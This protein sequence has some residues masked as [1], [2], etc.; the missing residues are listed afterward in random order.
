MQRATRRSALADRWQI[1]V[2][3]N[4]V[5][6]GMVRYLTNGR[7][8]STFGTGGVAAAVAD[9]G[10]TNAV[11][12]QS[13]G[14]F[15]VAGLTGGP[16]S[17]LFTAARYNPN[18]TRDTAFGKNGLTTASLNG[19]MGVGE[20]VLVQPDDKILIGATALEGHRAIPNTALARFN[21]DGSLDTTF[22]TRGTLVVAAVGGADGLAVLSNGEILVVN[23]KGIAQFTSTGTLESTVT[24]GAP[25]VSSP[26]GVFLADGHFFDPET[27]ST[28]E[29][30]SDAQVFE[31]DPN[32]S[33]DTSF[34]NPMFAFVA[35]GMSSARSTDFNPTAKWWSAAATAPPASLHVSMVWH[36][37]TSTAAW[38]RASAPAD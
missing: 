20:A 3:V 14:K 8:D 21:S 37:W 30:I 6:A 15:V 19:R 29:E 18:G 28:G 12:S 22:G 27:V 10:N 38:I 34:N 16:T 11:T 24:G 25:S 33:A 26:N 1:L 32:G 36:G 2:A 17:D 5:F 9:I 35:G 13:D 23:H 7:L 31:F 4:S